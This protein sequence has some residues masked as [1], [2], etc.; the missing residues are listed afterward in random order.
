M[1]CAGAAAVVIGYFLLLLLG[2][3][4]PIGRWLDDTFGVQL[5]FTTKGAAV[6]AGVMAFPLMVRAIR[7]AL[8]AIDP[9]LEEAARTL[10]ASRLDTFFSV[11]LPLMLPG[12]ISG[13][14]VAFAASLANSVR[15]S[16]SS[17]TSKRN[18]HAAAGH[19]HA[20]QRPVAM[21]SRHAWSRS[22]SGWRLPC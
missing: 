17:P 7:L 3:R 8:E 11:T 12:I 2:T 10:G 9:K 22:R 21:P 14:V 1:P 5:I 19:L 15:R 20:T 18:A 13:A 6:A 16:R 4:G